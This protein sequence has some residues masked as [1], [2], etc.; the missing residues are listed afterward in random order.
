MENSTVEN[1]NEKSA[2]CVEINNT[3]KYMEEE[4]RAN[5]NADESKKTHISS[6]IFAILKNYT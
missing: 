4:I 6:F 5:V 1:V 2:M 3:I